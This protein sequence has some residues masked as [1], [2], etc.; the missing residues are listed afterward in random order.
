MEIYRWVPSGD[1]IQNNFMKKLAVE[2]LL[3]ESLD[4]SHDEIYEAPYT[5]T[6]L[7]WG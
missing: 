4:F 2:T 1:S 5:G 6:C 3:Y 7:G